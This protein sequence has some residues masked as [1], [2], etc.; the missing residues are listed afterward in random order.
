MALKI[1][2][3][4]IAEVPIRVYSNRFAKTGIA[5]LNRT[6]EENAMRIRTLLVCF[7]ALAVLSIKSHAVI[8]EGTYNATV[9]LA[10][11]HSDSSSFQ[12]NKVWSSTI[13][14]SKM[15]GTFSFDTELMPGNTTWEE[16]VGERFHSNTNN[17]L[18][19]TTY[20]DGKV[21]ESSKIPDGY[22]LTSATELVSLEVV[23]ANDYGTGTRLGP[24]N[25]G[26]LDSTRSQNGD[27]LQNFWTAIS[28]M[29]PRMPVRDSQGQFQ[30][31][32]WVD[33][34]NSVLTDPELM[35]GYASFTT[36]SYLPDGT[37]DY[38]IARAQINDITVTVHNK[39][40]VPEPSSVLLLFIA[41][42]GLVCR[43]RFHKPRRISS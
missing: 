18:Q 32:I 8:V 5:T 3:K 2:G 11:D 28:F 27:A 31:F 21:Y 20:V 39:V 14:G 22:S 37:L 7:V 36:H 40:S 15:T 35:P 25:F 30:S 9:F 24:E 4:P 10:W 6:L 38:A 26:L 13:T 23:S 19:M 42:L 34:S 12:A 41:L 17:W 1:P 16:D 43:Y 29:D 33:D